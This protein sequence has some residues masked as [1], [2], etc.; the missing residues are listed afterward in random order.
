MPERYVDKKKKKK[1]EKKNE[2]KETRKNGQTTWS[3]N[4]NNGQTSGGLQ[5]KP[6]FGVFITVSTLSRQNSF[7]LSWSKSK[8]SISPEKTDEMRVVGYCGTMMWL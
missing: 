6:T 1:K 3:N 8:S 2:K 4:N 7:I 5:T